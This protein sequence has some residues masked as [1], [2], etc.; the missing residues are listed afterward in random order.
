MSE[1]GV[2]RGGC[3]RSLVCLRWDGVRRGLEGE[4]IV[5]RI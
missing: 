4:F 2:G 3:G 5:E 1:C